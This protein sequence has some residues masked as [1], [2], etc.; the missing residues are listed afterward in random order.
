MRIIAGT[1]GSIP[2]KVPRSLTRPTTD[3]VREAV[4][5]VLGGKTDGARV[6]DLFA[7]SGSLGLESL[8]RGAAEATLVESNGAACAVI[9][10]NLQKSRL[11]GA[12][13]QRRDVLSFLP[14]APAG[15]YDIIFADPPYARD[16]PTLALLNALV[17][18]PALAAALAPDGIFV[19]E[20]FAS[21]ALPETPLW[22]VVR[23]K[24]Y[25]STRVSYLTPL[26]IAPATA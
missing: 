7:G 15:H 23:E 26:T 14:T 18:S 8:S 11:D 2:L 22:E 3:R 1:A 9:G 24:T 19:L 20:S 6:L 17:T 16:E 21:V 10:E 5:S 4:F 13:V 12:R 25:G